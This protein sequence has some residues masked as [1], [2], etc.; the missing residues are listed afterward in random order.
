M[1]TRGT[2]GL[3]VAPVTSR[4]TR[5]LMN[6][7]PPGRTG[8][9]N[10][11]HAWGCRR[12]LRTPCIVFAVNLGCGH[13]YKKRKQIGHHARPRRHRPQRPYAQGR[14]RAKQDQAQASAPG[15]NRIRSVGGATTHGRRTRQAGESVPPQTRSGAGGCTPQT[16]HQAGTLRQDPNTATS[17]AK[18]TYGPGQLQGRAGTGQHKPWQQQRAYGWTETPLATPP[19]TGGYRSTAPWQPQSDFGLLAPCPVCCVSLSHALPAAV[20]ARASCA[21]GRRLICEGSACIA[22]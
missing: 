4:S 10:R 21:A 6:V 20:V 12:R 14:T 7:A 16:T 13:D 19:P 22:S 2:H 9:R 11:R 18:G 8:A 17:C 15:P 1:Y 5:A 3:A